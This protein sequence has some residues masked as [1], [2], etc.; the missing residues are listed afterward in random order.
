MRSLEKIGMGM[1]DKSLAFST[2]REK[3]KP[4]MP[5]GPDVNVAMRTMNPQS[6]LEEP[7]VGLGDDGWPVL[8]YSQ[9]RALNPR[10]PREPEREI[11]LNLTANMSRFMFSFN[12]K[13]YSEADK[14]QFYLNERLR[15]I[16]FNQT[17]MAHPIHLH[18]MWMELENG[19]G[20]KIPRLHTVMVKPGEKLSVLI[21]P[22][23][24]GDWAFHCHLLYHFH[25]GMFRVVNVALRRAA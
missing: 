23:E 21:T 2:G 19:Q 12:G 11:Y 16:M 10:Y 14:I 15:L 7:G 9:L 3:A 17:M 25:S 4:N 1:M 20:D 18:G 24:L 8:T 6:R 13:K 5:D 22:V